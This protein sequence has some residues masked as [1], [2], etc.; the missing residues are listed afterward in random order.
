MNRLCR[1]RSDAQVGSAPLYYDRLYTER[2]LDSA[3]GKRRMLRIVNG[4]YLTWD[5]PEAREDWF[6]VIGDG[7]PECG[8]VRRSPNWRR[9]PARFASG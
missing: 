1:L 8:E 5:Q 2:E 6:Q 9:K 7:P 3:A 4:R